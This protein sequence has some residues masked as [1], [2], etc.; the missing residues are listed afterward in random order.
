MEF[1]NYEYETV[2]V[3]LGVMVSP[4]LPKCNMHGNLQR[5]PLH[6]TRVTLRHWPTKRK[7]R[8]AT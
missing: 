3:I 1:S 6:Q 4:V 7:V 8:T 2:M 5:A